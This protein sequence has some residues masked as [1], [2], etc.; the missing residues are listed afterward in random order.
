M[1]L[2]GQAITVL[3]AA[4][5]T[6]EYH[7]EMPD[8]ANPTSATVTGCSVQPGGGAQEVTDREAI[9][10]L[11]TVWAPLTAPIVDGDRVTY[12]GE[13]YDIDGPVERWAVGTRL[14]HL[15][16]RLKEITG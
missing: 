2:G 11:F 1:R 6:D 13:T 14:D 5:V 15:V 3:S 9:T 16:I 10:T 4:T 12:A 8:W 7:N